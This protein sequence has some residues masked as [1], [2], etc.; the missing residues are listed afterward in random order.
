MRMSIHSFE[1]VISEAE[2]TRG[3]LYSARII[4]GFSD[5]HCIHQ[6]AKLVS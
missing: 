1:I 4:P 2:R 3:F 5:L 6:T